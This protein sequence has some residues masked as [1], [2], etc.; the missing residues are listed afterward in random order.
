MKLPLEWLA[1][2]GLWL[3]ALLVPLVA[4]YLL[5][6][7]R[8]RRR[9]GATWL[10]QAARR[11][12]MAR[13]PFQRF[14]VQLPLVLQ[15]L[16]LL[17]LA[18]AASRPAT[19]GTELS[20]EHVALII[21]T[22]ASMSATDPR[23][24]QRR[25]ELAKA[26]ARELVLGLR[27]GSDA[28]VLDAG[29]DARIALPPDRDFRRLRA[30]IDGL[31]ARDVE[32]DLGAA[33]A[34]AVSRLKQLGGERSIVVLSDGNLARPAA[35]AGAAVPIE[36]VR[37][38][39]PTDNAAI[40]RLD[41]RAGTDPL[42]ARE[43]VQAFLLVSNRGA[44]ARELFVTM[45][46]RNA[47]DVLDSRR[48][49]VA[50]GE[51]EPV[52]L[53]FHPAPGDYGQG[54]VFELS[55][56][57]ALPLDD[58]A[59]GRVPVGRKLPVLYAAAGTPSPWLLRA[60]AAD[61]D[62]EV[63]TLGVGELASAVNVDPGALVVVEGACPLAVPGGDLLLLNPPAGECH[64]ALVGESVE[65]PAITSWDHASPRLRFVSLDGVTVASARV[66][67]PESKRQELL[68]S[69]RGV[70][71]ADVSSSS[72]AAMLLGFDP[73]ESNWPL[74]ASFVLF[75]RNL[76]EQARLHRSSGVGG[77]A[78]AGDPLRVSVP[79]AARELDVEL[80]SGE[81]RVVPARGGLGVVPEADRVGFYRIGWK[82]PSPGS[83]LVPVNLLSAAES[84]LRSAPP[85]LADPRLRL[86]T[87]S[88]AVASHREWG[89]LLGLAALGFVLLDVWWLTRRPRPR[90]LGAAGRPRV[91][92]RRVRA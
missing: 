22:S 62:A 56:H 13:S 53:T 50:P 39:E 60:L 9:V 6:V 18:V 68:R 59:Y 54:L 44:A 5:K 75:A 7:R 41:V 91:P 27:P 11:D 76:M 48:L 84:D 24:G 74:K 29:R 23:T 71:A 87:P 25:I 14:V 82:L 63:R 17:A 79:S 3:G 86:S 45:R 4:L 21:D 12:L 34:L 42:L 49:T 85:E 66:L 38:G 77:P 92:E 90:A 8:Q 89:W 20:G 26:A 51:S 64:G 2:A 16:A 19:R 61:A 40:V 35:F 43:Q 81:R 36:L 46:E 33:L 28:M 57:D 83:V 55:P 88:A 31:D 32:G 73:G 70:L 10:W 37:V 15:A 47:S 80:P 30:A 65:R 72:R 52:V 67:Q 69:D 58:V 78:S 1:P